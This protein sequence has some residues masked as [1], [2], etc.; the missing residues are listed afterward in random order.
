VRPP[1]GRGQQHVARAR[2]R[3]GGANRRLLALT[4]TVLLMAGLALASCGQNEGP[5]DADAVNLQ[6]IAGTSLHRVTL[7]EQALDDIALRT[8]PVRSAPRTVA[9]V[10][11]VNAGATPGAGATQGAGATPNAGATPSAGA[12]PNAGA[13]PG[14]QPSSGPAALP[15]PARALRPFL[16]IPLSA[17]IYDP[18]GR[19][20]TYVKLAARTF[21]RRAVVVDHIDGDTV[22]LSAGP[23]LG[24]PVVTAGAPELLGAEYGVGEE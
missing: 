3:E 17:L 5:A 11:S 21:V 7:T 1:R 12:T 18:Q 14:T 20:W 22:Y 9:I 23:R 15:V 6:P 4:L 8:Q 19:S 10:T 13:T 16:V 24:T 2:S